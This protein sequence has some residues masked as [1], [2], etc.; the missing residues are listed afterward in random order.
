MEIPIYEY[1]EMMSREGKKEFRIEVCR[2]CHIEAHQ[3]YRRMR[4]RCWSSVELQVVE[5]IIGDSKYDEVRELQKFYH[6]IR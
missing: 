5:R 4:E 1:Y 3:F 6:E 2:R